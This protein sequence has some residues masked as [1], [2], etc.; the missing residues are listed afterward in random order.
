M[1]CSALMLKAEAEAEAALR[2]SLTLKAECRKLS[3]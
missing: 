3:F 2:R 1:L